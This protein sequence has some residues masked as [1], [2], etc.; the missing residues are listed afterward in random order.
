MSAQ[1]RVAS[2][3]DTLE[4]AGFALPQQV[5]KTYMSSGMFMFVLVSMICISSAE[6]CADILQGYAAEKPPIL[7]SD[8]ETASQ[9]R[10]RVKALT[11]ARRREVRSR[12]VPWA[13]CACNELAALRGDAAAQFT[14]EQE[15]ASATG[16]PQV[17]VRNWNIK[18]DEA[19]VGHQHGGGGAGRSATGGDVNGMPQRAV[20]AG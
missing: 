13:R 7:A 3:L 6:S 19:A 4:L 11:N 5:S 17:S 2:A 1:Q 20:A 10:A 9:L 16:R 15:R 8:R 18:D 12:A 14:Q